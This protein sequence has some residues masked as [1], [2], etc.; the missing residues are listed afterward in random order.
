[1]D[2]VGLARLE[3][4]INSYVGKHPLHLIRTGRPEVFVDGLT[5]GIAKIAAL[6]LSPSSHSQAERLQEQRVRQPGGREGLR[7]GGEQPDAGWRGASRYY[8]Q[9]FLP[10]FKLECQALK[11]VREEYGLTNVKAMIPFCRT[12]EEARR[13]IAIMA[14]CGLKR[15]RDGFEVWC[16]AEVPS[17]IIMADEFSRI[18]DGFS[19]GSNDLTQLTLGLDRT[20]RR[21]RIF[22]TSAT[23][24]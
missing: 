12:T 22:L 20:A 7:T 2:G 18:F 24:P 4:I 13:V 14:D 10:A 1:V 8:D 21:C 15:G 23:M 6:I 11:R 19:I 3:F 16:M 5:A 9:K 17:N